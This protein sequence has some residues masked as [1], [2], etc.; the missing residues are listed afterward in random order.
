MSP[1]QI[2]EKYALPQ[3]PD[4]IVYP[5]IPENIPLEVSI[6]GPQEAWGTVGGDVQYAIKD[7]FLEDDWFTDVHS[8][9]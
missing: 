4:K 9:E 8:L 5:K 1:E 2:A 6:A 7:A 3:V